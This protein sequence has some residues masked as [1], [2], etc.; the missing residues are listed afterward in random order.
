MFDRWYHTLKENKAFSRLKVVFLIEEFKNSSPFQIRTRNNE[1]K[2]TELHKAG[3]F[4]DG[5]MNQLTHTL[6]EAVSPTTGGLTSSRMD[7][8][9]SQ[10]VV[11]VVATLKVRQ[12][13]LRV[14]K[15]IKASQE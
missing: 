11:V 6:V 14:L 5:Y 13:Y 7:I 4:A 2:I 10:V 15:I 12:V 8:L 3:V 1:Q 9:R